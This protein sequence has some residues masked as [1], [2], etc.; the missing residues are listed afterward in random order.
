V[1]KNENDG[2]TRQQKNFD[3]T[4]SRFDTLSHFASKSVEGKKESHI[5]PNRNDISAGRQT[6]RRT[7]LQRHLYA[8]Q[9]T[10]E[11]TVVSKKERE[12][13][14]EKQNTEEI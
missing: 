10:A 13:E 14:F 9:H 8:L 7:E 3:D 11:H 2:P 5:D 1:M 12:R 6:D 4:F